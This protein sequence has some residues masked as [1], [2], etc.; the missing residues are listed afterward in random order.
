MPSSFRQAVSGVRYSAGSYTNGRWVEGSTTPITFDASIQPASPKEMELLP[1]ARR[2]S[3]TF[4]LFTD[5]QLLVANSGAQTNA[6]RVTLFGETYE[7][8]WCNIWQNNVI[9][10]YHALAVRVGQ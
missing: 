6:D 2:Q 8:L 5:T 7:I 9:P 4:S 3:A 1:E 10:H